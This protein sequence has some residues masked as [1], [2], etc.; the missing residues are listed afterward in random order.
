MFLGEEFSQDDAAVLERVRQRLL[1][2]LAAAAVLHRLIIQVLLGPLHRPAHTTRRYGCWRRHGNRRRR[3]CDGRAHSRRS[4]SFP[5]DTFLV[6]HRQPYFTALSS[7]HGITHTA[8]S[9]TTPQP[10]YGP[11]SGT[12]WVP[13]DNFWTL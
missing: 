1:L 8:F 4:V 7:H 13:E 6:L 9:T 12:T 5:L 2:Q 10:F 11:F 3:G